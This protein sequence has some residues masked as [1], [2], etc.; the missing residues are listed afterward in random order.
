MKNIRVFL[1]VNFQFLEVKFSIYL[2][3]HVFVM[4]SMRLNL[5]EFGRRCGLKNFKMAAM[6]AILDIGTRQF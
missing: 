5:T 1:S 4:D 6:V 2:N 3:R